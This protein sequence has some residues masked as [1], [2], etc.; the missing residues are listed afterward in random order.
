[1]PQRS[2]APPCRHKGRID[3]QSTTR[4]AAA[5]RGDTPA[6]SQRPDACTTREAYIFFARVRARIIFFVRKTSGEVESKMHWPALLQT[7]KG[8]AECRGR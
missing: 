5:L 6:P 2:L 8:K 1:M 7:H 4:T 3:R